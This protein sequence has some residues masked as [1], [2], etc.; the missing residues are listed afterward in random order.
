MV[1]NAMVAR[2]T[3]TAAAVA[4]PIQATRLTGA[5]GFTLGARTVNG[6]AWSEVCTWST[7]TLGFVAET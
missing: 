6:L 5:A 2:A 3:N 4:H 7:V 1:T